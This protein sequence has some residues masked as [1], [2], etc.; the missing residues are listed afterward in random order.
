MHNSKGILHNRWEGYWENDRR[1]QKSGFVPSASP[2]GAWAIPVSL[3][4]SVGGMMSDE[5]VEYTPAFHLY[6]LCLTIADEAAHYDPDLNDDDDIE[7]V[8]QLQERH[9]AFYH[10]SV[11]VETSTTECEREL[12]NISPHSFEWIE[13]TDRWDEFLQEFFIIPER[14]SNITVVWEID[15]NSNINCLEYSGVITQLEKDIYVT[16][17]QTEPIECYNNIPAV[18]N[19]INRMKTSVVSNLV[20]VW[21][22]PL[23][24]DNLSPSVTMSNKASKSPIFIGRAAEQLETIDDE[25]LS[26]IQ[27]LDQIW[28]SSSFVA[29]KLIEQGIDEDKIE[30]V[31][32]MVDTFFFD[33]EAIPEQD[34]ISSLIS[35]G[36]SEVYDE[37]PFVFLSYLDNLTSW[38]II[39]TLITS[40]W[41]EFY[42]DEPVIL[43]FYAPDSSKEALESS[44]L[45]EYNK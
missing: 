2:Y 16:T 40:F 23:T 19:A 6:D 30:V 26:F 15:A 1:S 31:A 35:F 12:L 34:D 17:L 27:K 11:V 7:G 39:E 36:D 29:E 44:I 42:E 37:D 45:I 22:T 20:D 13:F 4:H 8:C 25:T 43:I 14:E 24:P 18:N 33:S 10:S 9:R 41:N 32:P 21:V 38:D 5:Y 3:Y 28:A